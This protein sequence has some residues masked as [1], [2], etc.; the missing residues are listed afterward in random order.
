MHESKVKDSNI[1]FAHPTFHFYFAVPSVYLVWKGLFVENIMSIIFE[2]LY[3]NK[4]HSISN[5]F[6][7][8]S[9]LFSHF[10]SAFTPFCSLFTREEAPSL[11]FYGRTTKMFLCGKAGRKSRN[12]TLVL[13]KK[14]VELTG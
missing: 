11:H 9:S 5:L 8:F 13:K 3:S 12:L 10:Q 7:L 1:I 14:R 4:F 6:L 2:F